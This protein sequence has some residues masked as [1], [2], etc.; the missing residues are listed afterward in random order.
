MSPLPSL[1]FFVALGR[2]R[3]AGALAVRA[4]LAAGVGAVD[5]AVA[6][7]VD[8]VAADGLLLQRAE[9]R[10]ADAARRA[11]AVRIPAV[12][13]AIAVVVRAVRRVQ[14]GDMTV[15][16]EDPDAAP[17]RAVPVAL[18]RVAF[19]PAVD[20]LVQQAEIHAPTVHR[21]ARNLLATGLP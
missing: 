11:V 14:V 3:S 4:A 10:A 5:L 16:L 18:G 15:L 17:P 12:D 6:V 2:V 7:V 20:A 9:A 8:A 13:Q 1:S 21:D 19:R